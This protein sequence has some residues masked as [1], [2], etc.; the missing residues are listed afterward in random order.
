MPRIYTKRDPIERFNSKV[1]KTETCHIW[2]GAKVGSGPVKYG[3]FCSKTTP[4]KVILLAHRWIFE[5]THGSIP[6]GMFVLHKCDNPSCVRIDH[7][8]LGTPK[9]NTEDML[10]K[11]RHFARNGELSGQAKLSDKKVALIRRLAFDGEDR[12][13][14]AKRFGVCLTTIRSAILGL[15]WRKPT[16]RRLAKWSL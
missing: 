11:K 15:T 12:E 9:Q 6:D 8:F 4:P 7:L 10:S 3:K 13:S 16:D 1:L 14:L 5:Q 2:Q